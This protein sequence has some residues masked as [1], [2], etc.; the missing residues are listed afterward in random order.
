MLFRALDSLSKPFKS[1]QPDMA[2]SQCDEGTS[3]LRPITSQSGSRAGLNSRTGSRPLSSVLTSEGS[4][5]TCQSED[6]DVVWR[7]LQ[8]IAGRVKAKDR[9][10]SAPAWFYN[11]E[12]KSLQVLPETDEVPPV[13]LAPIAVRPAA[14][15]AIKNNLPACNVDNPLQIEGAAI[16]Q[17]KKPPAA[18]RSLPME[19]ELQQRVR[20]ARL[21]RGRT[22]C[23]D[24]LQQPCKFCSCH[25]LY[26]YMYMTNKFRNDLMCFA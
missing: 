15:A 2:E 9:K 14:K 1:Q 10:R 12:R 20:M 7:I 3:I 23:I 24:L 5:V 11:N 4:G 18:W 13:K 26:M 21:R 22:K 17:T 19:S 6:S 16:F 8:D 25:V